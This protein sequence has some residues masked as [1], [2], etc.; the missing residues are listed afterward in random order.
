MALYFKE[1]NNNNL[2]LCGEAVREKQLSIARKGVGWLKYE[3][4]SFSA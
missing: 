4:K 3:K 2:K 1:K